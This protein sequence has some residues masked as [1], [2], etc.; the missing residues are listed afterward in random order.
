MTDDDIRKLIEV[1]KRPFGEPHLRVT[2]PEYENLRCE[3]R[4]EL[5]TF[6]VRAQWD[7]D[8]HLSFSAILLYGED[9]RLILRRY[10]G[11]AHEHTNVLEKERLPETFHIH[12][13]TQKY[14]E[15]PKKVRAEGYAKVTTRYNSLDGALGCLFSDCRVRHIRPETLLRLF[16]S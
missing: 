15:S 12:T 4:S 5:G 6:F 16:E 3:L 10:N 8:D 11:N 13:A 2:R 7:R 14:L 9:E 1:P